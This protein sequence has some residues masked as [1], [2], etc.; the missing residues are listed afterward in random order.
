MARGP[1]SRGHARSST[2]DLNIEVQ[3]ARLV[4]KAFALTP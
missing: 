4:K 3:S 2:S 1:P